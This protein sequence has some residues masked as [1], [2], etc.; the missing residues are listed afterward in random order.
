MQ[1][2]SES[3]VSELFTT[4][5]GKL[6]TG[7]CEEDKRQVRSGVRMVKTREDTPNNHHQYGL[8]TNVSGFTLSHLIAP[9][10]PVLEFNRSLSPSPPSVSE[11]DSSFLSD[12][13]SKQ[14]NHS[15]CKVVKS[16]RMEVKLFT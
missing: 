13:D 1:I 8:M 2:G 15:C 11:S 5:T 14:I 9:S 16:R 12:E 3:H 6:P 7:N 4:K 10:L